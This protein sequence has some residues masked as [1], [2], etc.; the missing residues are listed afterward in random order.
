MK[1]V[2]GGEL[3]KTAE[4]TGKWRTL[5]FS[6]QAELSALVSIGPHA[7]HSAQNAD[8]NASNLV[9]VVGGEDGAGKVSPKVKLLL[10]STANGIQT[11][12]DDDDAVEGA[13]ELCAGVLPK[14]AELCGSEPRD[15]WI[16]WFALEHD[17]ELAAGQRA[18]ASA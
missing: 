5:R 18:I 9:I 2:I 11:A 13:T 8:S 10:L 1:T 16:S 14:S 3:A 6:V 15:Y 17:S 4:A 7:A 12:E